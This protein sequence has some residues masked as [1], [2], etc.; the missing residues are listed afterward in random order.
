[1][2]LHP[3]ILSTQDVQQIIAGNKV[4]HSM[5]LKKQPS[6]KATEIV[7]SSGWPKSPWCARY[8]FG[9]NPDRYEITDSYKSPFGSPGDQEWQT[10]MPPETGVYWVEGIAVP[11]FCSKEEGWEA[12]INC[13]PWKRMGSI[14]YVRE[15]W[16]VGCRPDQFQGSIEGFEYKADCGLVDEDDALPIYPNED[17]DFGNY[18]KEGWQSPVTMPREASRIYLENIGQVCKRVQDITEEEAEQY[19]VEPKWCKSM[20]DCLYEGCTHSCAHA[21]LYANYLAPGFADYLVQGPKESY[22][23][24]YQ[25]KHGPESWNNNDY[26]FS[27]NFKVLS[28]NGKPSYL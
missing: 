8:K 17:Y 15:A 11:V 28:I 9:T 22:R 24:M 10:G 6:S 7:Y 20:D 25:A 14:L 3:L 23:T 2:K 16:G 27:C 1:M 13:L 12:N 19:G 4:R 26:V 18:D 21:D 5:P